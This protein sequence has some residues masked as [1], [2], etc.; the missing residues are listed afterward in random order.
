MDTVRKKVERATSVGQNLVKILLPHG[1][2]YTQRFA[3]AFEKNKKI[4]FAVGTFRVPDPDGYWRFTDKNLL[5][6]CNNLSIGCLYSAMQ[7]SAKHL[8]EETDRDIQRFLEAEFFSALDKVD[9]VPKEVDGG[10]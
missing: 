6:V 7:I 5:A 2:V 8:S 10:V 9:K 4:A 1:D 3:E